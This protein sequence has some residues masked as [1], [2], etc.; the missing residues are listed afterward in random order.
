LRDARQVRKPKPTNP[1]SI[2]AHVELSGAGVVGT[3]SVRSSGLP[4]FVPPSSMAGRGVR[5]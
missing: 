2:I 4:A 1:A 5:A 3:L